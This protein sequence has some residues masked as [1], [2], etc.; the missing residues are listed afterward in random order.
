VIHAREEATPEGRPAIKW[1]L[2]TDLPVTSLDDPIRMLV[3]YAMHWKIE[4]FYNILKSSCRAEE[5]W[6][7][8]AE[9]LVNL[10][11]IFCILGWRLFWMTMINRA[12][13]DA[14]PKLVLTDDE[15]EIIDRI[16]AIRGSPKQ[17]D[18][19][20]AHYLT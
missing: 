8:T 11:A 19:P 12:A 17:T 10:I 9:R 2:I 20:L 6:L 13:P 3:C 15:V 4:V 1:K 16:T 5:A 14:S 18:R 7:R